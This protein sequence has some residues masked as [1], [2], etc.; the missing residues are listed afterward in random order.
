LSRLELEE[1]YGAPVYCEERCLR[2]YRALELLATDN[3]TLCL[4]HVLPNSP[5][6]IELLWLTFAR[7]A[8]RIPKQELIA[9]YK[10]IIQYD[11]SRL[12]VNGLRKDHI[13]LLLERFYKYGAVWS[14]YIKARSQR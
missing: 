2:F 6:A 3:A 12:W 1:E 11:E 7:V 5:E 9:T 14:D 13:I 4:V 10:Y 8:Q